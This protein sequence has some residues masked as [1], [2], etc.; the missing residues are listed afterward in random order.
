[1]GKPVVSVNRFCANSQEQADVNCLEPGYSFCGSCS[2]GKVNLFSKAKN[3]NSDSYRSIYFVHQ[4]DVMELPN[5]VQLQ[6]WLLFLWQSH[7]FFYSPRVKLFF[8]YKIKTLL[9][10]HFMFFIMN[11]Y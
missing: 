2:T 8:A 9:V 3:S 10:S 7:G 5:T 11:K 1:M 4:M 6:Y